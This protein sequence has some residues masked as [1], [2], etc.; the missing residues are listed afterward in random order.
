M[1][2]FFNRKHGSLFVFLFDGKVDARLRECLERTLPEVLVQK[3]F[4]N[5]EGCRTRF[6]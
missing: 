3:C 4:Q 2:T 6:Q 1:F 5:R